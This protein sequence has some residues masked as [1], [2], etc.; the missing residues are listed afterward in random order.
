MWTKLYGKNGTATNTLERKLYSVD[1]KSFVICRSLDRISL[2]APQNTSGTWCI[3]FVRLRVKSTSTW[4]RH[5][6]KK[7]KKNPP[8][9]E[10]L[11][12]LFFILK[13][14]AASLLCRDRSHM[15][16]GPQNLISSQILN[17]Y[18]RKFSDTIFVNRIVSSITSDIWRRNRLQAA[19]SFVLSKFLTRVDRNICISMN[20][21]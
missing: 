10:L 3:K 21:T 4:H 19:A 16:T 7:L 15:W 12:F 11:R 13:D 8:Q 2:D 1:I 14:K 9:T 20:N 6:L 18:F 17:S 5:T